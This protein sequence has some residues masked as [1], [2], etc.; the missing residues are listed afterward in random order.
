MPGTRR[1][2]SIGFCSLSDSPYSGVT[3]IFL[4]DSIMGRQIVNRAVLLLMTFSLVW[5]SSGCRSGADESYI[6][7]ARRSYTEA[8]ESRLGYRDRITI[9]VYPEED[10]T[11]TFTISPNGNINFP[12]LGKVGVSGLSCHEVEEVLGEMLRAGFLR[13]PS[14]TCVIAEMNSQKVTVTGAVGAQGSVPYR[15][16][17]SILDVYAAV[18]GS[19]TAAA[20]D[21]VKLVRIIDGEQREFMIPLRQILRGRAPNLQMWPGDL[22]YVPTTG[23]LE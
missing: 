4:V 7:L 2:S 14:V 5:C 1:T 6:E 8:P 9:E 23:L 3:E 12:L 17:L 19:S 16:D 15:E 22:V 20:Q 13:D 18:G 11:R 21:R 10:L